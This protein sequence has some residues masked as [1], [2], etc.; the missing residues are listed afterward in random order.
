MKCGGATAVACCLLLLSVVSSGAAQRVAINGRVVEAF[1]SSGGE[2]WVP[3]NAVLPLLGVEVDVDDDRAVLRWHDGWREVALAEW[4]HVDGVVCAPLRPMVE[5]VGGTLQDLGETLDVRVSEAR[6]TEISAQAGELVVRFDRFAPL[7]RQDGEGSSTL[8]FSCCRPTT[9]SGSSAFGP[10]EIARGTLT[11]SWS[12]AAAVVLS[13]QEAG[14]FVVRRS[15]SR[16]GYT[17]TVSVEVSAKDVWVTQISDNMVLE[18][19]AGNGTA[20]SGAAVLR[21]G[22]WRTTH[23]V[24]PFA[25]CIADIVAP[26]SD[27]AMAALAWSCSQD[28]ELLVIGGLPYALGTSGSLGAGFDGLDRLVELSVAPTAYVATAE[29]RIG[30]DAVARPIG[31]DEVVAYPPGYSGSITRGFPEGFRVVRLRDDLVVSV[32]ETPFVVAEPSATLIVA[33]GTSRRRLDSLAVGV[34]ASLGVEVSPSCPWILNAVSA[35]AFII[36]RGSA[37]LR[38]GQPIDALPTS[39]WTEPAAWSLV[40]TDW[41]GALL[42]L[43]VPAS[44]AMTL[45]DLEDWLGELAVPLYAAAALSRGEA[46]SLTVTWNGEPLRLGDDVSPSVGLSLVPAGG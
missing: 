7:E 30:V 17:V 44:A 39:S 42:F 16:A 32:V 2:V 10:A 12:S 41:H 15:L 22:A 43:S 37:L 9:P 13:L 45:A 36:D 18:Q 33:S 27:L 5:T 11:P 4:M 31:Y 6:L 35:D 24:R 46:S 29:L 20:L 26:R 23:D 8:T 38:D 25:T 34:R 21:V 40:A 19:R 28:P 3:A 1:A 14:E